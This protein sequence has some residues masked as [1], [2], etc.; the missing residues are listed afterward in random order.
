M[1]ISVVLSSLLV[2]CMLSYAQEINIEG[3]YQGKNL[4]IMNPFAS[5][6]VGYCIHEVKVNGTV[7]TDEISSSAFEIDL[8]QYQFKTGDRIKITIKHNSGCTPKVLNPEVLDPKSTYNV[9]AIKV[10]NKTKMLSFTTTGES[11]PL[12]FVIEQFRWNK[13]IKV[14]EIKGNGTPGPNVYQTQVYPHSGENQFRVK[15]VDYTKQPRYSRICKFRSMSPAITYSPLKRITNEIIF[16]DE[17]MYELYNPYGNIISRGMGN[18][19]DLSGLKK[20]DKYK[21]TLLY[22]NQVLQFNK[23]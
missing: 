6:G 14:A 18:K 9:T 4:Y 8:S 2:M 20:L 5:G 19:V 16:S 13:W 23:E 15:Q 17:T 11:G 21:Y 1:R 22:D 7:S 12:P 3:I 10:D